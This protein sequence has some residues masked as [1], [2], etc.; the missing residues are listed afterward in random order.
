MVFRVEIL[1]VILY[2][3]LNTVCILQNGCFVI[4]K[5]ENFSY[6]V[7]EY[8]ELYVQDCELFLGKVE[9]YIFLFY[10]CNVYECVRGVLENQGKIRVLN[11]IFIWIN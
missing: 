11:S 10:L 8:K 3:L 4:C 5:G 9:I 7:I 1:L 2:L 6:D